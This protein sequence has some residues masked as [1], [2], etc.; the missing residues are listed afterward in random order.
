MSIPESLAQRI[1]AARSAPDQ[2]DLW[3][4]AEDEARALERPDELL[5]AYAEALAG[6]LDAALAN[7]IGQR[8]VAFHDEW[9]GEPDALIVLLGAVLTHDPLSGWAF[10]RLS[11]LLNSAARWD[12]LLALYDRTL[13][14]LGPDG[15][16]QRR[17]A[18]LDEAGEIAK[19]FAGDPSR[20]IPYLA[21]RFA[22][23]RGNA[24]VARSL[25]RLYE[26]LNRPRDLIALWSARLPHLAPDVARQTRSRIAALWLDLD[27]AREALEATE[28]LLTVAP[29]EQ[30]AVDLLERLATH[31]DLDV[32]RL[33]IDHLRQRYDTDGRTED[34]LRMLSLR[35]S[36]AEDD[37]TR[38]SLHGALYA[39]LLGLG[40]VVEATPHAAALLALEPANDAHVAAL[41]SLTAQT[42]DHAALADALARAADA[43]FAQNASVDA[44]LSRLVLAGD[45]R[46]DALDDAAG[47]VAVY[48]RVLD[49]AG[50][51][52]A[53]VLPVA[54]RLVTLLADD[55]AARLAVYETLSQIETSPA[56][57]RVAFGHAARLAESR[58]ELERAL[59]A[60]Q[61]RIDAD[62]G[63]TEALDAMV[64]LLPRLERWVA[65]VEVLGLRAQTA[66]T[67]AAHRA[68]LVA[69]ANTQALRLGQTAE[70]I[71][72][73]VEIRDTYGQNAETVDALGDLFTRAE[74]WDDL[75]ALLAHA[76]AHET[77]LLRRA[78]LRRRGGD[79][80]RL[81]GDDPALALAAYSEALAS[82]P[83]EAGAREGLLALR[84]VPAVREAAIVEL[85]QAFAL[86][87]DWQSLVGI[88]EDRV[89]IA[90][91]ALE[92]ARRLLE[93]AGLAEQRGG[94]VSLALGYTARA[95]PLSLED[96]QLRASVEAE[97]ARLAP[98][99][100]GWS[101][102]VAAYAEALAAAGD[103]LD[104]VAHLAFVQGEIYERELDDA[105][106]ALAS[107]L[108]I[109][110]AHR[111]AHAV[112][113][114][115]VRTAG[116]TDTWDAAAGAL[117]DH[118]LAT[119]FVADRIAQTFDAIT[120]E[121]DAWREALSSLDAVIE[122]TDAQPELLRRLDTLLGVWQRDRCDDTPAA[123][124]TLQ[125]AV[126]RD[127]GD[128][129]TLAMLADLQRRAPSHD[130]LVSLLGLA[131]ALG[132]APAA[133]DVLREA[134]T[135]APDV[136][137]E[138]NEARKIL[139]R[140]LSESATRW[141]AGEDDAETLSL[142]AE[143]AAWALRALVDLL[144]AQGDT[145][146]AVQLLVWGASL[147]FAPEAARELR[148][149]AAARSESQ[150]DDKARAI[151]LYRDIL[152]GAPADP[153]AQ[154]SLGLLYE[155]L[156]DLDALIGLRQ[157]ALALTDDLDARI[158]LRLELARVFSRRGAD[159]DIEAEVMVLREN[160][161]ELPGEEAT[162]EALAEGF[163]RRAVWSHLHA[164][165]VEQAGALGAGSALSQALYTRAA[166]LA[167]STLNAP[168]LA[169][170]AWERVAAHE[171]RLD[172]LTALARL[173]AAQGNHGAAIGYLQR[174]LAHPGVEDRRAVVATLAEAQVD[175][176]NV[177]GARSTLAEHL[178]QDPLAEGLRDRLA[179]LYRANESWEPLAALLASE[180]GGRAP[181][182]A[183]L[184]EAADILQK[185]LGAPERA[186]PVLEH[187]LTLGRDDR[188]IRATL[189]DAFRA[190][191]RA[192]EARA[193]LDALVES[194]GRQRPPE[195]ALAHYH[196][197]QLA[198]D[199]GDLQGATAQL[200]IASAIDLT[201]PGIFKMLG[202]LSREAE[203]FDKAE[204]AYRAL[205]LIVRRQSASALQSA[206]A[207]GPSEVL[208]AL[209]QIAVQNGQDERAQETL[210]SAF[211]TAATSDA[212]A[213]RLERAVRAQSEHPLLLRVLELRLSLK[214][215]PRLR[216]ALLND[217]AA[218]LGAHLGRPDEALEHRLEALAIAPDDAAAHQAARALARAQGSAARYAERLDGLAAAAVAAG[219][220]TLAVD[221]R[222]RLGSVRADDLQDL[223]G[224]RDAL[225]AAEASATGPARERALLTLATAYGSLGDR[226]GQR[227]ALGALLAEDLGDAGEI[228][229]Q[230][231]AL[232]LSDDDLGRAVTSLDTALDRQYDAARAVGLLVS[233]ADQHRN[234]PELLAVY[235]RVAR[236]AGDNGALLDVLVRRAGADDVSLDA[237]REGVELATQS[238]ALDTAEALLRRAVEVAAA[239]GVA[240]ESVW[241]MVAL[242]ERRKSADDPRTALTWL[243]HAAAHAEP[244]EAFALELD[245][246][247]LAAGPADDLG[248][249]LATYE[250][251]RLRDPSDRLVWEPLLDV[252]RRVGDDARREALIDETVSNVYDRGARIHLRLERARLQLGNPARGEDAARSLRE[253]LDEDPDDTTATELLADLLERE[254]RHE[255]LADLLMRQFDSARERRDPVGTRALGLRL[256]ALY[257][258][259]RRERAIDALRGVTEVIAGDREVL[260]QWVALQ[261]EE[262][263]MGERADTLEALL[264]V[265]HGAEAARSAL[266]LAQ[267]RNALADD[268]G[269]ERAL[270]AGFRAMPNDDT[271]RG[272]LEARYHARSHWAGLAAMRELHAAHLEDPVARA[273]ALQTAAMLYR[274]SLGDPSRASTL[275]SEARK[276]LPGDLH[277]L[278]EHAR[279]HAR[280]GDHAAAEREVTEALGSVA[281]S[282]TRT[283]LLRLRAELRGAAQD[284]AGVVSDLEEAFSLVGAPVAGELAQALDALRL[285]AMANGDQ[286]TERA[287]TLRLVAVLPSVGEPRAAQGYLQEWVTRF[288]SDAEALKM[289]A[290]THLGASEWDAAADVLERLVAATEGEAKI[291]AAISLADACEKAGRP[292]QA[293]EGLEQAYA[294]N[295]DHT[296]L[297]A[298]L[299]ALYAALGAGVES[300]SLWVDEAAF[301]T[302][303]NARFEAW[304]GA[305]AAF[306]ELANDPVQAIDALEKARALKPT[307]H[308]TTVRLADAFTAAERID[309]ASKLL[310]AGIAAHKGRR[311]K[312]LATLQHR[313]ARL[314]YAT[315]DAAV[316]LAWLN[317]ALDTDVQNGQ[318]AAEL[319]DVAME[320]NNYDVAL[321]ALRAVTLMKN[322]GP[323]SRAMAF[324]RQ[325]QIAQAQ[326]DPKKAVFLARKALSEDAQLD[327][328]HQF[329]RDLGVE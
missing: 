17:G 122:G 34:S 242:A 269:V 187:C 120:S 186:I 147:P 2:D 48:T 255:E 159:G 74:R 133:L 195:R 322:P 63:D 301:A 274:D 196:L 297:R 117:V 91:S 307:D 16:K 286:A 163:K 246:A 156:G 6:P 287:V 72:T 87:D 13:A 278:A 67:A 73:W 60:W 21:A 191:G 157:H 40:R 136:A 22:L 292:E 42:G 19:D 252:L 280:A 79:V 192:D 29:G 154:A 193:M 132:R 141:S 217:L 41:Q 100:E 222:L 109:D 99:A 88:V 179:E 144:L 46:V 170:A 7:R 32:A 49:T 267:Y 158:A 231:A 80:H 3:A 225:E 247:A 316:E 66:E 150:L 180:E 309:D 226:A 68:D 317:A 62:R 12:D 260:S 271:L 256:A 64:S 189:A 105:S 26:K 9:G 85:A 303:D 146:E 275:L 211:E 151:T 129:E 165:Y 168:A 166:A 285:S 253:V 206:D 175:V 78:T 190:A 171:E 200:E 310:E 84:D 31:A 65:L 76:S 272:H 28:A 218:L 71:T 119:G 4:A 305:G 93:A 251:L 97:L 209:Y 327:E 139:E 313:M 295:R 223:S 47:A 320:L 224:A 148:R 15:D 8:A 238:G 82:N 138:P 30:A 199:R 241:A 108:R 328:A 235:E 167:E 58:G 70:A 113:E 35:L 20:S 229:W 325:G 197:A 268:A 326:G 90:A 216:A 118:A 312:E 45:L 37:A 177:D 281:A 81:R 306:V 329:L 232:D 94:D 161:R 107:F 219:D 277:L 59:S 181:G 149:E 262:D 44:A 5:A 95:L 293:R 282:D 83:A 127:G 263:P 207:V 213:A 257:A 208:Y 18:L 265:Q 284:L 172:A 176:G 145:L 314:A 61:A 56:A 51:P 169:I 104:L 36:V 52:D 173:Y 115:I 324:L 228:A 10:D 240:G 266:A 24:T 125:R 236:D 92:Q 53:V 215:A 234:A 233:A 114:A 142:T 126:A 270:E 298:R 89:S 248:Y 130:L 111:N 227:K 23:D 152:D 124:L 137:R 203:Q 315:G 323:M 294:A 198:R 184:R 116:K 304:R 143:H 174:V 121:R 279:T 204:R 201:H 188:S 243:R 86:T 50:A 11:M 291:T 259:T 321:K 112:T 103:G 311:S 221:L 110:A 160:L 202:E 283:A 69:I 27:E 258:P 38:V 140:L 254:H 308:E 318:V 183:A 220:V 135:L 102:V 273:A 43:L 299:R 289:L 106:R 155:S 33:A 101:T 261:T 178:A 1:D 185:R 214:P 54:R 39:R 264:A 162:I 276:L 153:G 302:D 182:V 55:D 14:A 75:V 230:L 98:L 237:L 244:S 134:A 77:D 194:F 96:A 250:R 123:T 239:R 212:E 205:L 131:D 245:A 296:A 25:E 319:A 164:L 290:E 300:A 288:P 128:V 57:R 249:A 210:E